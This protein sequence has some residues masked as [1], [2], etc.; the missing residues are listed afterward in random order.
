M[1]RSV[2]AQFVR[3]E[4]SEDRRE[5]GE[6]TAVFFTVSLLDSGDHVLSLAHRRAGRSV[7]TSCAS[8]EDY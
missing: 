5:T 2:Q 8:K 3:L 4:V 7:T 1:E 6:E